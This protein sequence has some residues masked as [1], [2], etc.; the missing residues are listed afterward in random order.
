MPLFSPKQLAQWS[1]GVWDRTPPGSPITGVSHDT[2]LI[3]AGD[4]FIALR[5]DARDG[6]DFIADAAR[7]GAVAALVDRDCPVSPL[8]CLKVEA[9]RPALA[10]IAAN[11]RRQFKGTVIG[12]TGSCGKT[13]T[14]DLLHRLLG[15]GETLATEANLNNT[16]GVPLTLLRID[17][18]RHRYAVIE[19]GINQLGEMT[20]MAS[21]LR[22]D[23]AIITS[24]GPAHL[25]GLE[26]EAN[27]WSEKSILIQERAEG[28]RA[29]LPAELLRFETAA[30]LDRVDWLFSTRGAVSGVTYDPQ[31]HFLGLLESENGR[32]KL[33][34]TG[35][36]LER[37]EYLL[38][39]CSPGMR[40]N[41]RLA[42]TAA[43]R[44]GASDTHIQQ[45]LDAWKPSPLRGEIRQ[46][47]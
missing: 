20:Q 43:C 4:L 46:S 25:D 3:Q 13:S 11:H 8:P 9:V 47:G 24:I 19:A 33:V 21:Q 10:T 5:G 37:M 2:R 41:M 40:S 34:L 1:G 6:H 30:K 14:K 42:I 18:A 29:L 35:P 7:Q 22:P 44:I 23:L 28:G 38:P 36:G 45:V 17:P 15:E 12:I 16:L 26:S 31:R 39:Q 32:W 27:V